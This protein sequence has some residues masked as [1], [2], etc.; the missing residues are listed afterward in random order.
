[1]QALFKQLRH[2]GLKNQPSTVQENKVEMSTPN[3]IRTSPL[4]RSSKSR[5]PPSTA[6]T[7]QSDA[8]NAPIPQDEEGTADVSYTDLFKKYKSHVQARAHLNKIQHAINERNARLFEKHSQDYSTQQ[9][10]RVTTR[11]AKSH[12]EMSKDEGAYRIPMQ[13]RVSPV[14]RKRAM[15]MGTRVLQPGELLVV[16]NTP[17][18]ENN[19]LTNPGMAQRERRKRER[20]K[21]NKG[22]KESDRP[23]LKNMKEHN[24]QHVGTDAHTPEQPP[25]APFM[26]EALEAY[27]FH[28][29]RH[30]ERRTRRRTDRSEKKVSRSRSSLA[31]EWQRGR[32][33]EVAQKRKRV[34][35][36]RLQKLLDQGIHLDEIP[37]HYNDG[38]DDPDGWLEY[39][40]PLQ[41]APIERQYLHQSFDPES[42]GV[43][44]VSSQR[45]AS[46]SSD[47]G[48]STLQLQLGAQVTRSL[49]YSANNFH[50]KEVPVSR[51]LAMTFN[52]KQRSAR[53]MRR[54][55]KERKNTSGLMERLYMAQCGLIRVP[56]TIGQLGGLQVLDL[57]SNQ[58]TIL[59]DELVQLH[60]L[61]VLLL[62]ANRIE[63]LPA[64]F[65]QL[66]N[67][68]ELDVSQNLIAYLPDGI[69][70]C[71]KLK[72]VRYNANKVMVM[73]VF[74]VPSFADPKIGPYE[75]DD[76]WE[77]VDGLWWGC[78]Y[79]NTRTGVMKRK[80]P[81]NAIVV[82][83][84]LNMKEAKTWRGELTDV[85][86]STKKR[87]RTMD[88]NALQ[89]AGA[90]MSM[91]RLALR[92]SNSS[93]W[94]VGIDTNGD[95]Y[96]ESCLIDPGLYGQ[97]LNRQ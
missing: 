51:I 86:S 26:D 7:A 79:K 17:T 28:L 19:K 95:T 72:H 35:E 59:P 56:E 45:L 31:R 70:K 84:V 55:R 29:N 21:R 48:K 83:R 9:D 77:K 62:H 11:H 82:D 78:V 27:H 30:S 39:K 2:A 38:K 81:R 89:Q 47:V 23:T 80:P 58:L 8:F 66:K 76:V 61:R 15:E 41:L 90:P 63:K 69:H 53:Q 65:D 22:T 18:F 33:K 40:T 43:L 49:T 37:E 60:S 85:P 34:K 14:K 6:S 52:Q 16:P 92:N 5:K 50:G 42:D 25:R 32:K 75:P 91:L 73:G 87:D 54:A 13:P 10:R 20:L 96:Y 88:F 64:C 3:S 44:D 36:Q 97:F 1:M 57:H 4:K 94:E 46:I 24:Q 68:I 67:L 71:K 93:E 74:P 12:G